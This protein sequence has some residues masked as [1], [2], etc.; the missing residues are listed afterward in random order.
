[1]VVAVDASKNSSQTFFPSPHSNSERCIDTHGQEEFAARRET[2][3]TNTSFVPTGENRDGV[4]RLR[5]PD[6]NSWIFTDL[7]RCDNVSMLVAG[8]NGHGNDI[9]GVFQVEFLSA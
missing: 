2:Q 3:R 5:I 9:I 1:M 6:M 4:S 8:M 7:S